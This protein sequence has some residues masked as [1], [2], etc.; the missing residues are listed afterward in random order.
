MVGEGKECMVGRRKGVREKWR[1][2]EVRRRKGREE[3]VYGEEEKKEL[4]GQSCLGQVGSAIF[5]TLNSFKYRIIPI[6]STE[7]K[8]ST[9][10][11]L[12]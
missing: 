10:S 5:L 9:F 7:A 8:K 12:R 11:K 4:G 3:N 6:T 2:K 1:R